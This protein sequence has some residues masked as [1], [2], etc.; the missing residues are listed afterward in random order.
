MNA[1]PCVSL[2]TRQVIRAGRRVAPVSLRTDVC[3][4]PPVMP[5]RCLST[6][7]ISTTLGLVR[8]PGG[9]PSGEGISGCW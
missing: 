5:F 1:R 3:V 2:L 6:L 7:S 9:Q 8:H 4:L